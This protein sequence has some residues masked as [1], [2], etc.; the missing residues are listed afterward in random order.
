MYDEFQYPS[1]DTILSSFYF[2]MPVNTT[3][4]TRSSLNSLLL[5]QWGSYILK[6]FT[7]YFARLSKAPATKLIPVVTIFLGDL[8]CELSCFLPLQ[9]M[10]TGRELNPCL[11]T[12]LRPPGQPLQEP[13]HLIHTGTSFRRMTSSQLPCGTSAPVSQYKIQEPVCW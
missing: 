9:S 10:H 3:H 2:S 1:D 12:L 13:S 6:I 4:F 8:I 5:P 7:S 11:G